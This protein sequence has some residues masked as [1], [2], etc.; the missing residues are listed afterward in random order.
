MSEFDYANARLR[1]MKSRLL[2]RHT[3]EELTLAGSVPA[4]LTALGNTAYR[5][6]VQAAFAR[7][8][9][10]TG[11]QTLADALRDDLVATVGRVREFFS[12]D[13]PARQLAALVLRRYD[14]H[15]LKT[16]LRG[17]ARQVPSDEILTATLPVGDLRPVDLAELARAASVRNAI[18][19]LATWRMPLAQPLLEPRVSGRDGSAEISEMEVALEHW[20]YRTAL[21]AASRAG[22]TGAMLYEAL[23]LQADMTNLLTAL[24]LVG[25]TGRLEKVESLFVGPGH[26]PVKQLEAAASQASVTEALHLLAPAPYGET[27]ISAL[28]QYEI[29]PR[30]SIFERA[31]AQH[32]LRWASSLS[33]R[34]PLGIGVLIGYV[35]LK[36]NEIANL[37]MIAQGLW[38]DES[39]DRL[40]AQLL[41]ADWIEP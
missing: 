41:F 1:A 37:R 31:L 22:A 32:E 6:A 39:P 38:L 2:S 34:D 4:L 8:S 3:L 10:P 18:D 19:L 14:I 11:L 40:R 5:E 20:H 27:L 25:L 9:L 23:Q 12:E 36:A 13:S 30:L 28:A 26:M 35:V 21:E 33:I 16:V 24:R 29:T 15:N 7:A 17:L